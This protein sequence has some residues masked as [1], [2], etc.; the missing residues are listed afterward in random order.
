MV[1]TLFLPYVRLAWVACSTDWKAHL[2]PGRSGKSVVVL[3]DAGSSRRIPVAWPVWTFQRG[4]VDRD[5]C[6]ELV[7]GVVKRNR[8]DSTAR[9]RVQVWRVDRGRLRPG[10]L[11]T[12][13]GGVLDTFAIDDSGRLVVRE[14]SGSRWQVSRWRWNTFGFERDSVLAGGLR[15]PRFPQI[16]RRR[17]PL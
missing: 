12:R 6:D 16:P 13:L 4:D 2:E 10:W 1:P 5:G 9:R 15:R 3:E 17:T 8:F 7:L 14:Q 11:G